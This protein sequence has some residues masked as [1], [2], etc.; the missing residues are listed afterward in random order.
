MLIFSTEPGGGALVAT[1]YDFT[2]PI[3]VRDRLGFCPGGQCLYS[4]TDPGY[5]TPTGSRPDEGL[6]ALTPGTP[7]S[8]EIVAIEAGVSIKWGPTV[9]DTVGQATRIGDA[10]ALHEHPEYQLQAAEGVFGEFELSFRLTT[11]SP[12]YAA[13]ETR[14]FTLVNGDVPPTATP[15][16]DTTPT[17]TPTVPP[18]DTCDGDCDEDGMVSIAELIRGVNMALGAVTVAECPGF[19][20]DGD[21][22]ISISELI[23]AVRDALL[24][25]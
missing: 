21:G 23:S 9:L 13:S 19:D 8:F 2:Q 6:H 17:A 3:E 15:P 16:P 20:I 18:D 24:G 12:Q 25:C 1:E 11:T 22:M 7:V 4:S 10:L 14:R 5:R